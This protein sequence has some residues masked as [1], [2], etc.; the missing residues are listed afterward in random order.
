MISGFRRGFQWALEAW[1]ILL[2]FSLTGIVVGA[3]VFRKMGQSLGWTD[4]IARVLLAWVTYYGSALAALKR[5]HIG[6]PGLVERVSPSKR[7]PLVLL[8]EVFVIGFFLL[9]A[10]VGME[11]YQ[12]LEGDTLVSL[13]WLPLRVTQSVIPLGAVLFVIAE[14]L[15][16][17]ETLKTPRLS[18]LEVHA[19]EA[20]DPV[21]EVR[22]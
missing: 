2:M 5:A 20:H 1:V 4:E 16:L 7:I 6:F 3:V 11:V 21:R 14:L 17:P 12:I 10:W 22:P 19:T 15:S 9:M 18:E 8:G 13:T